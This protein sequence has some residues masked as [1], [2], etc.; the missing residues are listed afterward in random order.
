MTPDR[1][2]R[3]PGPPAPLPSPWMAWP[4]A[5][6]P[7]VIEQRLILALFRV[8]EAREAGAAHG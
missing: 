8:A 2:D 1:G 6:H 7:F 5:G 3:A 4:M